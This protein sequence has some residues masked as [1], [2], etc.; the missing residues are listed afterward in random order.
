MSSPS[1]IPI[2]SDSL[3]DAEKYHK[4]LLAIENATGTINR[5]E[6]QNR[7]SID[8][9]LESLL[10]D[11]IEALDAA[12]A[13]VA[14]HRVGKNYRDQSF[15]LKFLHPAIKTTERV[16][17]L[18]KPLGQ[19]MSS[20]RARVIEPF[21]DSP[22][23]F[24]P[25]LE[26]F[27][28]TTAILMRM[29]IGNQLRI[30]GICNRTKPEMGPFLSAD[31]RA[32]ESIIELIAI[33]MRVGEK[34]RQELENIQ[35]ISAAISAEL[36]Q[37][38]LLPLIAMKT[39]EVFS[40]P[41]VSL[42]LWDKK[43]ESLIIEA[44]Y[45]LSPEY[46][47]R[48]RI[49]RKNVEVAISKS[50]NAR[51][52]V[53]L[54]L[55]K[56]PFG[57]PELINRERLRSALTAQLQ[58]SGEMIGILNIYSQDYERTFTS[59]EV[60]LAEILANH[61]AIA[62]HNSRLRRRDLEN[63]LAT[64][65]ALKATLDENDLLELI[66]VKASGV[67]AAP[68]SL[69]FWDQDNKSLVIKA[70][71]GLSSNCVGWQFVTSNRT[72]ALKREKKEY[73]PSII[74]DLRIHVYGL[75]TLCE[76]EQL[77]N[78]LVA[79][80]AQP[81]V[82]DVIGFLVIFGK[83]SPRAFTAEDLKIVGI[84]ADQAAIA[85]RTTQLHGENKRRGEQLNAL[86][87]IALDITGELKRNIQELLTS[88]IARATQLASA[89]GGIIYLWNE[90]E[91]TIRPVAASGD[92]SI[93]N[94]EV[95]KNRGIIGEIIRNKKSLSVD[96]YNSWPQRQLSLDHLKLTSA[97]GVP[98][99]SNTRLLGIIAVHKDKPGQTF[100]KADD[101]LLQRFANH[102]AVAIE[103]ANIYNAEH[104]TMN[105]L[106]NLIKSCPDGIIVVDK[107]GWVTEYNE[108]AERIIGYSRQEV[109]GERIHVDA[110]YGN[111]QIPR[112]IRRH[113]LDY[114]RLDNYETVLLAKEGK[115]IPIVLS[116]ALLRDKD[117]NDRGSVGFF[118][119]LRPLRVTLDTFTAIAKAR[120]LDEGLNALAKGMILGVGITFCQILF[121]EPN[122]RYLKVSAAYAVYRSQ[123]QDVVW[124]PEAGELLGM[125]ETAQVMHLLEADTPQVYRRGETHEG[126]VMTDYV[127]DAVG[128]QAELQSVLL[129]PLKSNQGMIGICVLGELRNWDRSPFSEEKISL[130]QSI[131]D[132]GAEL[133][134]RLQT[135]E[136][137]RL[138]AGL[139]KA[140]KEITSLQDL[141]KILKSIADGVREA[142][143]CE[144][145]TLYSYDAAKDRVD[146]PTISGDLDY[147]DAL[148]ALGYVSKKSIV[149]KILDL[150]EPHFADDA[151]HD[152]LMI[153]GEA[154]RNPGVKPFVLRERI[155][156]SA[157]IPLTMGTEKVGI[158]F[159]SYRSPHPF[160]EQEKNDIKIFAT[161]AAMAIY[162]ARLY[163]EVRKTKDYL[164]TSQAVAWL[165]LF[166][167][168]MQH[169][170]HQKAFS[171]ENIATGLRNWLKRLD[172]TPADIEDVLGSLDRLDA[173]SNSIR[174][175]QI[176]NQM[177][178]ELPG[179]AGTW[180]YTV[181]DEELPA[182]CDKLVQLYPGVEKKMDLKCPGIKA[183]IAPEGLR[184]AMEKLVNNALKAMREGGSLGIC[185]E[186]V[187]KMIHIRISDTGNGIP[188][189]AQ[190]YFLMRVVPKKQEKGGTGTGV[191]IARFVALSHGGDL[192]LVSTSSSGTELRMI[193][194][195]VAE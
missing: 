36:N 16:I 55:R 162:N 5:L 129:L 158:L 25:G 59:G 189:E 124:Q 11:L 141:P 80:I 128:L 65:D 157:G 29:Q 172:P 100:G 119:D 90:L 68:A 126:I 67:F 93:S 178:L 114:S 145:V 183:M 116:A 137:L 66:V 152:Q 144:L 9:V 98:I 155:S 107:N 17:P 133:I 130:A 175:V 112:A 84:I 164:L 75:Q 86:D 192:E 34:R 70:T 142:L 35:N 43:R 32:L 125:E 42:M 77:F 113:L 122:D 168:D 14:E 51:A 81:G 97:L 121:R 82:M 38:E 83:E 92:L 94:I 131:A 13:F 10:P 146:L 45:G 108:G 150:G 193:L 31:R 49:P 26:I 6:K 165:G 187:G 76:Q 180:T 148:F 103:N 7:A 109:L 118:K 188:E 136:A 163:H 149:W 74:A 52:I 127:K 88:I 170:I 161:Q 167:A 21:E 79:P 120:D 28:A 134:H 171:L 22:K 2:L 18:S 102:A 99:L 39:T 117:G 4:L 190:P 48:Q 160:I 71:H 60:E 58:V 41:A 23:K 182:I 166:G 123:T 194:P 176:T 184:V 96:E 46:V 56:N 186:R 89:Q 44:S 153:L 156:S 173:L 132:Q 185:T 50:Q 159:A 87:E 191:L 24:I 8:E 33:G 147:P 106:D 154:D 64:S 138:R 54:D 174:A 63:L 37:D 12:Q 111:P 85:I 1:K 151:L 78:A 19:I 47:K 139:L 169:T 62:I 15:E 73:R 101:E 30:I 143:N 179:E 140:G 57:K 20:N 95:D 105:Y 72:F 69:I 110:L 177:P 115:K 40:A 91:E 61:A 195:V 3:R 53:T 135:Y 181:I 104:E 27:S